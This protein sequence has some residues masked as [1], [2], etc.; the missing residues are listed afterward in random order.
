MREDMDKVIVERPRYGSS[1]SYRFSRARS[2][3][4]WKKD[5][6]SAPT[7]EGMKRYYDSWDDRKELNEN[8]NPL[9]RFLNA[10]AGRR[11]DDVYSEI[12]E[13]V[14]LN[15]A[16]QRHILQHVFDLVATKVVMVNGK[17]YEH[18]AYDRVLR[19]YRAWR[20]DTGSYREMYVNNET[21]IL[22]FA[23]VEKKRDKDYEADYLQHPTDPYIR[24]YIIAGLWYEVRMKALGRR[25]YWLPQIEGVRNYPVM[26]DE[27]NIPPYDPVRMVNTGRFMSE[28]D[29]T[30]LYSKDADGKPVFPVSKRQ[31][32]S[33]EIRHAQSLG[34][35]K[36]RRAA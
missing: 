31:L 17:P 14:K 30:Y 16:I 36:P 10:Q 25:R 22:C 8:L 11:W 7:R 27:L 34:R 5:P 9:Y 6:E 12:C 13:R 20:R 35:V 4:G 19:P 3:S 32:N 28:W 33:K 18:D 26:I 1:N 21:G 23:P 15:S 29:V 24:Y 2:K